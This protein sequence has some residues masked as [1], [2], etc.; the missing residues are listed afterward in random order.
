MQSDEFFEHHG[1]FRSLFLDLQTKASCSRFQSP[2]QCKGRFI[3][4]S[5]SGIYRFHHIGWQSLHRYDSGMHIL[6]LKSFSISQINSDASF[7]ETL[8]A[9]KS[10]RPT[11]SLKTTTETILPLFALAPELQESQRV[12]N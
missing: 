7:P 6:S 1:R 10:S 4:N 8:R 9:Q 5:R 3:K 2:Q 12:L 11:I